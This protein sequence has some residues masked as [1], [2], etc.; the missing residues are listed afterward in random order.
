MLQLPSEIEKLSIALANEM[1][2]VMNK[3]NHLIVDKCVSEK[4]PLATV[5]HSHSVISMLLLESFC[6]GS[7]KHFSDQSGG[8]TK[9]DYLNNLVSSVKLNWEK[10]AH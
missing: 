8:W 7:A 2:S 9:Y 6:E 1:L 4:L 3:Q 10:D 5:A